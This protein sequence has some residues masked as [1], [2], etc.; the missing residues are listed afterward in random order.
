MEYVDTVDGVAYFNDSKATNPHAAMAVLNAFD[1]PFILLA[2]GY[3]KGSDFT[4]MGQLI[5]K[6]TRSVILYGATRDRIRQ[7]IPESHPVR[8]TETLQQAVEAARTMARPG[9]RVILAPA[10]ASY[11]QFNDF[12]HRGR[13]FK[14]LVRKLPRS[15]A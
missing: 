11:D 3:E 1:E 6:K 14:D 9:E 13:V 15:N 12:E 7:S 8:M 2:G 5:A 4:E 10:C